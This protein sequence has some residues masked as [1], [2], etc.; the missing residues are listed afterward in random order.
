MKI[1]IIG[2]GNVATVL[3][4][5]MLRSGHEILQ[6]FSRNGE[7]AASLADELG[8]P[9]SAEDAEI[10]REGELYLAAISDDALPALGERLALP[11]KLVAHTAGA[12][13]LNVLRRVTENYG[14][15]YPLQSLRA[16][17]R[18][19]PEIP[20]LV[21]GNSPLALER[22]RDFAG[23]ISG[24]VIVADDATRGKLHLAGVIVNN[25][26]NHLYALTAAFCRKE[27]IAFDL[28]LPLIGETAG[29]L[30]HT[31]PGDAQT[32]P[33]IRGDR[34]TIGEH[35]K[36]LDNYKDIKELYRLMTFQIQ[37]LHKK[38]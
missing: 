15:L 29:R 23:T 22:I 24:Q 8:C 16:A 9:W 7:H 25:F 31:D 28:L 2:S 35:L 18:A 6:V 1:V 30:A 12:I 17:I 34:V 11:G 32:G 3:G 26:S 21:D 20:L 14:V 27:G 38:G 19:I 5:K 10:S 37:E 4:R 33:A 13:S 36:L